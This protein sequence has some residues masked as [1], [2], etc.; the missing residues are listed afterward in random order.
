MIARD[1]IERTMRN[2]P[3][4]YKT[5]QD[6]AKY[7]LLVSGNGYFW[8]DE[9]LIEHVSDLKPWEAENERQMLLS[10]PRKISE[11]MLPTVKARV[12][13]NKKTLQGIDEELSNPESL[14]DKVFVDPDSLLAN[15]P[16]NVSGDWTE[17][18]DAL[19]KDAE[20]IWEE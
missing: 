7:I 2:N 14:T 12:I 11:A 13:Q 19:T 6:T 10:L 20:L 4:E 5:W 18:I 8:N 9:G 15:S 17:A 3:T 1:L 16:A